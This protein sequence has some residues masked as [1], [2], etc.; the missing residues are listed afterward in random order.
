MIESTVYFLLSSSHNIVSKVGERIHYAPLPADVTMPAITYSLQDE[1]DHID[2]DDV[3]TYSSD[4]QIDAWG[5]NTSSASR[6]ADEINKIMMSTKGIINGKEIIAIFRR[7]VVIVN[8]EDA[9][10]W[11]KS[12]VYEIYHKKM[13]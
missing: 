1:S 11:R 3:S 8:E 5:K 7:N 10:G 9:G 12:Q 4:V 2:F 13:E 6:L